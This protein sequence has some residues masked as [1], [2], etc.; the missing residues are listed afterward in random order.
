VKI[1]IQDRGGYIPCKSCNFT[2]S[3]CLIYIKPGK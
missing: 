3:I 2:R 1:K